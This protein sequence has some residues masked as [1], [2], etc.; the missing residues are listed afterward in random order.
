MHIQ[1]RLKASLLSVQCALP[2]YAQCPAVLATQLLAIPAPQQE[3]E[4]QDALRR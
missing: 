1:A 3:T 4:Q 2:G